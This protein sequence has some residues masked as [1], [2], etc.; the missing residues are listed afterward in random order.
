MPAISEQ[1]SAMTSDQPTYRQML[2]DLERLGVGTREVAAKTLIP[3]PTLRRLRYSDY[4][5]T[6]MPYFW[7]QRLWQQHKAL[8]KPPSPKH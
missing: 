3:Y 7:L 4:A 8:G 5:D 6:S 2:F 1:F